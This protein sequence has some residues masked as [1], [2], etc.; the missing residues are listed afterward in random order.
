MFKARGKYDVIHIAL[1]TIAF[2][3]TYKF[4]KD[5][6]T[7][8]MLI[9]LIFEVLKPFL[10]IEGI[11]EGKTIKGILF[12]SVS[13][14]LMLLS[15]LASCSVLLNSYSNLVDETTKK[16]ETKQYLNNKKLETQV[17]NN[18][19][20]IQKQ[21]NDYPTLQEFTKDI[22]ETHSTNLTK[23]T[24]TWQKGKEKL[25]NDLNSSNKE[26]KSI[27]NNYNTIDQYTNNKEITY[28]SYTKIFD[29]IN[30]IT[31]IKTQKIT[32]SVLLLISTLLEILIIVTRI[33]AVKERQIKLGTYQKSFAEQYQEYHQKLGVENFN[34]L[35][36]QLKEAQDKTFTQEKNSSNTTTSENKTNDYNNI[37]KLEK[38]KVN[39]VNEND[40]SN[41]TKDK[42]VVQEDVRPKLKVL[43]STNIVKIEQP[44]TFGQEDDICNNTEII[45][46]N[47]VENSKNIGQEDDLQQLENDK[48]LVKEIINKNKKGN[49]C[50]GVPKI[51]R[52]SGLCKE[53][54]YKVRKQ[55]ENE[56]YIRTDKNKTILIKESV[57]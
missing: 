32:I 51:I 42:N 33:L 41:I 19:S 15:L 7:I 10:M 47:I 46:N 45:E 52:E 6:L 24:D 31:G 18:I 20:I 28:K 35:L 50:P 49:V 40:N 9:L 13:T 3:V 55:L 14:I 12:T 2:I 43:K 17:N 1:V 21:L 56:G 37:V 8:F 36:N 30:S 34:Y 27:V 53:R 38:E 44:E 5:M 54:V 29:F 25:E 57:K 4:A 16:V 11:K 26:L 48:K 23:L 39:Y 22:P